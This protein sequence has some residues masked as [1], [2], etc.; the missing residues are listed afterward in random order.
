MGDLGENVTVGEA[1]VETMDDFKEELEKSFRKIKAGDV[2][3]GTVVSV[4]DDEVLVDLDYYAPGVIALADASDDPSYTFAGNVEVGQEI[5]ATVVR[6]DDGQGRIALSMKEAAALAAW[7]RIRA[8]KESQE[9]VTVKVTEVTKAGV[10]AFLEGIRGFIPASKLALAYV[11]EEALKEYEGK[12]LE[13]RVLDF[14]EEGKRL[15]M[16]ARDILWEK[17]REEREKKITG[18]QVG[19]VTEGTV[20][21]IKPYGAFVSLGDGLSG[22]LHVSQ[23]SQKRIKSPADVLKEGQTVKVKV[24]ANKDGKISLSMKALEDAPVEELHE[25]TYDLPETEE[26]GTSLASLFKNIKL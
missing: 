7:D 18:V 24:I 3:N 25:E 5:T 19:T 22:L 11:E 9:N 14:G 23:I 2:M 4:D 13:V 15:I 8:L 6:R 16:S 21:T 20:E 26:I 1:K 10:V 12:S 17:R